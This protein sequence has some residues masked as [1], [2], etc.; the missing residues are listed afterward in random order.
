M[1]P[2]SG[3][4]GGILLGLLVSAS[5]GLSIPSSGV[6]HPS[7]ATCVDYTIPLSINSLNF[8]YNGTRFK[9]DVDVAEYLFQ[10]GRIDSA[11]TFNPVGSFK[12]ETITYS[13]A[14]TFCTPKSPGAHSK[15]V[16]LMTHGLGY[17]RR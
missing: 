17:D 4:I 3:H 9:D 1:V 13:I 11:S 2:Q 16:L 12:N 8:A 15:T 5:N 6:H 7:S 10:A 14:G